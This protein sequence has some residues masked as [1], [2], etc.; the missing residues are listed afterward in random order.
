MARR[1]QE[2]RPMANDDVVIPTVLD[3]IFASLRHYWPLILVSSL[4]FAMLGVVWG[5]VR[6]VNYEA[7]SKLAA[8][9]IDPQTTFNAQ[10]RT[11]PAVQRASEAVTLLNTNDLRREIELRVGV[12]EPEIVTLVAKQNEL[13]PTEV[14]IQAKAPTEAMAIRV[15]NLTATVLHEREQA[16]AQDRLNAALAPRQA[17]L[18]RT[19]DELRVLRNR[20]NLLL[21]SRSQASRQA[22]STPLFLREDLV[23]LRLQE[24]SDEINR[25]R[26]QEATLVA[27]QLDIQ[28][29]LVG[30]RAAADNPSGSIELIEAAIPFTT[31]SDGS[32]PLRL[33]A[34]LISGALLGTVALLAWEQRS[35]ALR[36]T[37]P[38]ESNRVDVPLIDARR[39][40]GGAELLERDLAPGS[41]LPTGAE[42]VLLA[43]QG[44]L[45]DGNRSVMVAG[46]RRNDSSGATAIGLA[47]A[48]T[49]AGYRTALVSAYI[50]PM[51]NTTSE[52]NAGL[53]AVLSGQM[54]LD[55]A[56]IPVEV[57]GNTLTYLPPGPIRANSFALLASPAFRSVVDQLESTHDVV[58]VESGPVLTTNE[59]LMIARAVD[60]VLITIAQGRASRRNLVAARDRLRAAGVDIDAAVIYGYQLPRPPF[61]GGAASV[62]TNLV[63]TGGAAG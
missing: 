32:I 15:A 62:D 24:L 17:N 10:I 53:V 39:R 5:A 18:R 47:E 43:T 11:A 7:V 46:T 12:T 60:A 28:D 57:A 29:E 27:A 31:V 23:Q 20:V 61:V 4:L 16:I 52:R 13:R 56:A 50:G 58:I 40:S 37:G 59:S 51:V 6:E 9:E 44:L 45:D 19:N 36:G 30:L 38:A 2:Q 63:S 33:V 35:G 42:E 41:S 8:P 26:D 55:D 49:S 25:L 22:Q 48:F 14:E 3:P 1:Q 54:H 34:G 21:Q